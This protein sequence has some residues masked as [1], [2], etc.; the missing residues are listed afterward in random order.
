MPPKK[1]Q[2]TSARI[3]SNRYIKTP[4]NTNRSIA[5]LRGVNSGT[6]KRKERERAGSTSK[7]NRCRVKEARMAEQA[8]D[9]IDIVLAEYFRTGR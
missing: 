4:L 6:L 2:S 1:R 9:N 7:R 3:K 8:G 5:L